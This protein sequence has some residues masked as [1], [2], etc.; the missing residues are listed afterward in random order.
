M[1]RT[2]L[3]IIGLL[4]F[5]AFAGA[6]SN[7]KKVPFQL[8]LHVETTDRDS[9][10]FSMPVDVLHPPMRVT[11]E[12]MS[13]LSQREV[14]AF[15]PVAETADGYGVYFQLDRFGTKSLETITTTHRGKFLVVIFN[16]RPI[17]R[18]YID[19]PVRDGIIYIPTGISAD[20]LR[21]IGLKLPLINETP[22]QM[23]K[24]L[25]TR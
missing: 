18:L 20:E 11:V 16:N 5:F 10:V 21:T 22:E 8:G 7:K 15:Y 3:P 24:R 4:A 14:K 6:A 9:A 25:R 23:R 19:R 1:R 13:L 2:L 12:K 17:C